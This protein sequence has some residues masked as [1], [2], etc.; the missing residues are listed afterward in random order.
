MLAVL[1]NTRSFNEI[2]GFNSEEVHLYAT[3]ALFR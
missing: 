3:H 2:V 1:V